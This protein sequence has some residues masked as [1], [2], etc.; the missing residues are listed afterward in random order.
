MS[1]RLVRYA[2]RYLI[3]AVFGEA[4]GTGSN[5]GGGGKLALFHKVIE[6]AVDDQLI[7]YAG[8]YPGFTSAFRADRHIDIEHLLQAL[9]PGHRLVSLFG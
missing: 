8:D 6:N 3:Q 1:L 9:R 2:W 4:L 5:S 7:L